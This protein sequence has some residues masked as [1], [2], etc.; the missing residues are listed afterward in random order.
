[1]VGKERPKKGRFARTSQPLEDSLEADKFASRKRP[2]QADDADEEYEKAPVM[3]DRT[4]Q[5][6]IRVAREQ[7]QREEIENEGDENADG[8]DDAPQEEPML[9]EGG[10][11]DASGGNAEEAEDGDAEEDVVIEY[12]DQESQATEVQDFADLE[13][14]YKISDEE[15][16]LLERF[17]PATSVQSRNLADIIMEKIKAAEDEKRQQQTGEVDGEAETGKSNIDKRVSKVYLAIGGIL[18][19]Y[20]SGKI[21]KALKVL[22]RIQNWEQLIMLTKPAEW[23]PHATYAMTRIFAAGLNEKM[24]QRYYSAILLPLFH[25]AMEQNKKLH[26]S[27]YM[28]VR[29]ALFKPVAFYK[30]FLLPLCVEGECTLREALVAGS[31]LQKVHLP[32]IPTA[33]VIVK[34]SQLPFSSANC[35]FLRV[36]IDKKMALPYQAIDALVA[37]FHRFCSSHPSSEALPVLWHQTLLS[38]VTRYKEDFTAEQIALLSQLCDCHFHYLIT[39]EA[40]RELA[41]ASRQLSK[42]R[43]GN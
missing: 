3:S 19:S 8:A 11:F 18:H 37:H 15:K 13:E 28:A 38:F 14:D 35:V 23:S 6:I 2:G 40:R 20:T 12:D 16:R 1:M 43:S 36:L 24:A 41:A 34:I 5:K 29:K 31:I 42:A 39:P 17:Q 32:P 22:P 4:T 26:P 7:L 9:M 30:G 21:P 10:D 25:E 27:L 33:V